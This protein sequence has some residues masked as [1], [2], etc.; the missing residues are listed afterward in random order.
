MRSTARVTGVALNTVVKLLEDAGRACWSYNNHNVRNIKA[1]YIQCDE[2]WSFCYAKEKN[3]EYITQETGYAGN[4]WTWT[5]I[6]AESKLL[7]SWLV[8][9][10]R[11]IASATEFLGELRSRLDSYIQIS[12]DKLQSY[13]HAARTTF[14]KDADFGQLIKVYGTTENDA[15]YR[16]LHSFKS[17]VSGK[18][19]ESRISTAHMERHN[20]TTRMSLRRYTRKTN[21]FSKRVLKHI[22]AFALYSV[23][24]NFCR[25]HSSIQTTPAVAAGLTDRPYDMEWLVD[26]ID[27]V[28]WLRRNDPS[29]VPA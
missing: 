3:V 24:Y 28:A 13:R 4:I 7:I 5:A 17:V 12:T 23:W 18:P 25:I 9:K 14:G 16:Y 2:I 1:S 19:D 10:D 29:F 22:C 21:A 27:T 20:L 6:D 11:S 26:L 15:R 8:A